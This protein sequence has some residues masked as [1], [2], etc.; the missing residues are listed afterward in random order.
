MVERRGGSLN[1]EVECT[2]LY[3]GTQGGEGL[4]KEVEWRPLF[5]GTQGRKF[6]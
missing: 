5:G 3:G 6:K 2:A 1:K 4:N